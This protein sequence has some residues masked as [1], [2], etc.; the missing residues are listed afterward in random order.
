MDILFID[1]NEQ[2]AIGNARRLGKKVLRPGATLFER[3]GIDKTDPDL[4]KTQALFS[5]AELQAAFSSAEPPKVICCDY[6]LQGNDTGHTVFTIL[7]SRTDA[8]KDAKLVILSA[9][10]DDAAKAF[11]G[12]EVQI[13]AKGELASGDTSLEES[14]AQL[15]SQAR[16]GSGLTA[17]PNP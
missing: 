13:F 15:L 11:A 5:V 10:D 14:L 8:W 1:D 12:T 3:M 2:L 4:V 16:L 6:N 7:Q 17:N 9:R